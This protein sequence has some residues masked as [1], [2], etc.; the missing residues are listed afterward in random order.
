MGSNAWGGG[1][2]L[3]RVFCT[4]VL[5]VYSKL[6]DGMEMSRVGLK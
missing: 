2:Q 5:S 4:S 3:Y 1:L 6:S